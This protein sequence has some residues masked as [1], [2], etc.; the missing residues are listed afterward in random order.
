MATMTDKEIKELHNAVQSVES[1]MFAI[2]SVRDI[3]VSDIAVGL[4][5]VITRE[6]RNQLGDE[7]VHGI[8]DGLMIVTNYKE[9]K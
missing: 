8:I 7:V 5:A 9:S 4:I 3:D 1:Y 6:M 2:A